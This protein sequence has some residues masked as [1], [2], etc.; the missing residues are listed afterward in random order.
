[1][2][3]RYHL[4]DNL[5]GFTLI[6]MMF[7]HAMYNLVYIYGVKALWYESNWA[8]MWQQSICWTFILLSGFCWSLGKRHLKRGLIVFALSWIITAI[9]VMLMPTNRVIFG[10]LCLIGSA[11]LLMIPLDKILRKCNPYV[12]VIVALALFCLTKRVPEGYVGVGSWRLCQLP[13]SWYANYFTAYLGLPKGSFFS[14]DYF[15]LVPWIFLF[16]AGYFLYYI[17]VRRNW[18][19]ILEKQTIEPLAFL[20]RHSLI[21]YVL[22]QPIIYG[23]MY[24]WFMR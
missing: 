1:M 23:L 16:V 8:Y 19:Y 14:L 3:T 12:G 18:F 15:P 9:T 22:H 17:F 24:L 20:G 7:Y 2:K 21:I 4:L 11:M 13:G 10:V 6:S 5:R